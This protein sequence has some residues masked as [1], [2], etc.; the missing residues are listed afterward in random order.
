MMQI[1]V[2]AS[3]RFKEL[4]PHYLATGAGGLLVLA[5][6]VL[7]VEMTY[8]IS[9]DS[10]NGTAMNLFGA[11]FDAANALP[12]AVA[13]GLWL[14]GGWLFNAARLRLARAWGEI[15]AGIAAA[16]A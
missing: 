13:G 4:V 10:A 3:K 14:A 12:W 8:K 5:A 6:L 16:R 2:I 15:Q 1:Q 11:G 7:T 9:V